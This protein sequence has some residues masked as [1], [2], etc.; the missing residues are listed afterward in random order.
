MNEEAVTSLYPEVAESPRY[1]CALGGAYA[2]T[3]ATYGNVPILHSGA[4][5]GMANA[6]GLTFASGLNTGG[7]QGTTSTPCSCLVEEHVIFGG[8]DKL[9]DLI[10]STIELVKGDLFTVISGCVPA[11]IGD[12]VD[13]VVG[14]FRDQAPVIHVNTA[15][16]KGS[17]YVGYE[18]YLDAVIEQLL[19]TEEEIQ[20]EKG[21]IN[22]IGI[23]P[24]QH[25]YW[26]G[27]L[28]AIKS[29]LESVGLK[30]NTLFLDFNGLE[31]L[32]KI[33]AAELNLVF[34]PWVGVNAAEKLQKRFGTPFEIVNSVPVGPKE[35]TLLLK[36][37]A[38]KVEVSQKRLEQVIHDEERN[39]YRFAEYLSEAFMISLPH[40]FYA[41]VADSSTAIGLVKYGTNELGWLPE[42]VILTDNPPEE[43]Q[44]AIIKQL[45]ENLEGVVTPKVVFEI[46]AHKIRLLLQKHTLQLVLA[47]SLEKYI[48]HEELNA[49]HLSIA[50]PVFDKVI[51]DRSYAGYRG[52][53]A[54]FEDLTATFAGPL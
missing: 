52:G 50:Y 37:I 30:A 36:K 53:L 9:R 22:I 25:V 32:K 26:K 7:T 15:G 43:Y 46:D 42:I 3:L 27:D 1:T 19:N 2:S 17:A 39:A 4:G 24:N 29:L 44:E 49:I 10:R 51:V 20:K 21:L 34:S 54:L 8:E 31:S 48:A 47:S 5:C 18:L 12:D 6:H 45:T 13:A 40:A 11:L 35:S 33:P 38:E 16:F 41:V 28:T 14:E 23:V